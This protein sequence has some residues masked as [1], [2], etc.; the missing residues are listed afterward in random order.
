[1]EG[2]GNYLP[3]NA[4]LGKGWH[5]AGVGKGKPPNLPTVF[6]DA[7]ANTKT[8]PAWGPELE[9][10]YPFKVYIQ[11][12]M[13]WSLATELPEEKQAPAVAMR[14]S[15]TA[16]ALCREMLSDMPVL[17]NGQTIDLNDGHGP[18][19]HTGLAILLW[20]LAAK[21]AHL[22][23]ET[24]VVAICEATQFSCL[25]GESDDEAGAR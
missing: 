14:L 18:Q 7:S 23:N 12:C 19:Q 22:E 10:Q 1:M 2:R 9:G 13:M 20:R 16:R 5:G 25:P 3:L 24:A 21:F 4:P 8:P 15:G 11:D 17:I 6:F